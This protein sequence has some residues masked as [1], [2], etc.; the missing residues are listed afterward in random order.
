MLL[1]ASLKS[2]LDESFSISFLQILLT[3][4][5]CGDPLLGPGEQVSGTGFPPPPGAHAWNHPVSSRSLEVHRTQGTG[6]RGEASLATQQGPCGRQWEGQMSLSCSPEGQAGDPRGC[7]AG[8]LLPL[9]PGARS[10]HCM[11]GSSLCWRLTGEGRS[12]GGHR[13]SPG[14]VGPLLSDGA[15]EA[16]SKDQSDQSTRLVHA[17]LLLPGFSEGA[18]HLGEDVD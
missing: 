10:L 8:G 9:V 4:L 17:C 6:C 7:R 14:P 13:L 2:G 12:Q 16:Y 11:R 18:L 1:F 3:A 5:E 15:R